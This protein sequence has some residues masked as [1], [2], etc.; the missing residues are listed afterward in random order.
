[1]NLERRAA[2]MNE[3]IDEIAEIFEEL[4]NSVEVGCGVLDALSYHIAV[5][6]LTLRGGGTVTDAEI[7]RLM[8]AIME[9]SDSEA[10]ALV[11]ERN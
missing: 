10:K 7:S 11:T 5:G 3:V 9:T 1:M 4:E 6:V 2:V 8:V